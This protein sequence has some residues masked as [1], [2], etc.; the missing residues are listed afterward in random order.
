MSLILYLLGSR[1]ERT[2]PGH[3]SIRVICV[4]GGGGF[5]YA[6]SL[7]ASIITAHFSTPEYYLEQNATEDSIPGMLPFAATPSAAGC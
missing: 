4:T 3:G 6:S 2:G 7:S 1:F 5:I